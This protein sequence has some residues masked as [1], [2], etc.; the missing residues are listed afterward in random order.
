ML[1]HAEHLEMMLEV[2]A[3]RGT[4]EDACSLFD[5]NLSMVVDDVLKAYS[6]FNMREKNH[7]DQWY[8]VGV[9]MY[10]LGETSRKMLPADLISLGTLVKRVRERMR[11]CGGNVSRADILAIADLFSFELFKQGGSDEVRV[12]NVINDYVVAVLGGISHDNR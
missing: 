10:A 9:M 4:D 1:T 12:V 11:E 6:P 7:P 3:S 5:D 8:V 2:V